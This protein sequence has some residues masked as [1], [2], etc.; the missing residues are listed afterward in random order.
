M[1]KALEGIRVLDFTQFL[2]GPYCGLMLADMGAEVIKIENPTIGDFTRTVNPQ[3]KGQSMYFNNV[4]R[5]KKSVTV[6]LKTEEGKNLFAELVKTADVVVENNRPGVM[7][8]L[9]FDYES[10][11]NLN[12]KIIF[13]S[14]SG[15]GQTG[16]YSSLPGYDII[17]QAMGGA[18]SVTGWPEG[19]ATRSGVALGD[20]LGGL[21]A[22]VGILS[23]LHYRNLTGEGQSID[24]SLVDSIVSSLETIST[25]YIY[26]GKIPQ[27]TGNRYLATYPYDSFTAMDGEYVIACGTDVHFEKLA[28]VMGKPELAGMDRFINIPMRKENGS[29]LKSII[30]QWGSDKTV[31][32]AVKVILDVGVPAAPILDMKQVIEDEH[33]AVA[34]E[35]FVDIEHP[36]AGKIKI[37]GNPIKMSTTK[38][39][40]RKTAPLLGEDSYDV[41]GSLGF[42]S[43]TLDEYKFKNII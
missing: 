5:N 12:S 18:M 10:C 23:A 26:D 11:K 14:I 28:K 31:E 24:V 4:N 42:D 7:K 6:N 13:A 38:T 3:V 22:T 35:M 30:D 33:I 43:E 9:G 20:I 41:Y 39:D 19:P 1:K 17:A 27:R 34:R 25:Q 2:A 37:S 36:V 16:P 40:I 32:E 21:N 29:E 8:R 15:F